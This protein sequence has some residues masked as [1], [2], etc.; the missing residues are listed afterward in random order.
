M[1]KNAFTIIELLG[2][3]VI[4]MLLLTI[5]VPIVGNKMKQTRE[6][7]T[8]LLVKNIETA[9]KKMVTDEIRLEDS[10]FEDSLFERDSLN[11]EGF[12]WIF[13]A[14]LV[15]MKYLE[16]NL[17]NPST[18]E[19]LFLDDVVYVTL[20]YLKNLEVS[21]DINQSKKAQ[22]KLNEN[23]NYRTKLGQPFLDPG[24]YGWDL[25]GINENILGNGSVD[26]SKEGVYI[27]EYNYKN[28]NTIKRY[29]IVTNDI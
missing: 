27:I 1:K 11:E 28:S 25:E 2:V 17:I 8:D 20:D 13:L 21:Y 5:I 26:I 22:I 23:L 6:K 3:L 15:D 9:A 18:K 24:A 7:A 4:I 16:P 14:D 29:V 12:S 19:P 10:L